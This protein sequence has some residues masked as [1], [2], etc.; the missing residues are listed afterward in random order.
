MREYD[1]LRGGRRDYNRDEGVKHVCALGQCTNYLF[2]SEGEE[3]Q[4]CPC[5]EYM[6]PEED[7]VTYI[8]PLRKGDKVAGCDAVRKAGKKAKPKCDCPGGLPMSR[9]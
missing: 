9:A 3:S 2:L 6:I 7:T 1:V 8:C 5:R 4:R